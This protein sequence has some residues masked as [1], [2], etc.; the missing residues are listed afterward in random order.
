MSKEKTM[1]RA[2]KTM[3]I[4]ALVITVAVA[5]PAYALPDVNYSPTRDAT[6]RTAAARVESPN[7]QQVHSAQAPS[8]E[9]EWG[10]AAI[11]AAIVLALL[12]LGAGAVMLVGRRRHREGHTA[13]MS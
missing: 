2:R 13:A 3:A 9:F 12:S 10:D 5:G 11:G 8:N 6:A 1:F 4:A 7:V